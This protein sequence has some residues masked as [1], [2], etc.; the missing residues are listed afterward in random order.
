[1]VFLSATGDGVLTS[2]WPGDANPFGSSAWGVGGSATRP[3]QRQGS[4][5]GKP[6]VVTASSGNRTVPQSSRGLYPALDFTRQEA[7]PVKT[8]PEA[9]VTGFDPKLS[10]EVP[11][12]RGASHRTYDNPDGSRSTEFSVDPVHYRKPDGSWAPVGTK[13]TPA[14]GGGWRNTADAVNLRLAEW[15]DARD[16]ATIGLDAEHAISFGLNGATHT[17][18]RADGDTVTYPGALAETDLRLQAKA[19]SVKEILVLRSPKA[20]RSFV[21]PLHLSGLSASMAGGKVVLT[22]SSGKPRGVIPPGFMNDTGQRPATST[23]VRYELVKAGDAPALQVT[24]D[25]AWLDAPE[26]VYPVEVDPTVE[27]TIDRGL[28]DTSMVVQGS[29]TVPGSATLPAGMSGGVPTASY[30]KFNGLADTLRGQA[31]FGASLSLYNQGA[32]S[33]T[34]RPIGVYPV[35]EP[36][37]PDGRYSYPGPAVGNALASA[38]FAH[39]STPDA[40]GASCPATW[41]N[42]GLLTAGAAL[43]RQWVTD[44]AKNN[45]LSLRASDTDPT[46]WKSFG[47]TTSNVQPVLWVTHSDYDAQYDID[48]AV[49]NP[50]VLETKPGTLKVSVTNTGPATWDPSSVNLTYQVDGSPYRVVAASLAGSVPTNA[51]VQLDA[52]IEALPPGSHR[53]TFTMMHTTGQTGSPFARSLSVT[54]MVPDGSQVIRD[55]YPPNGYQAPTLTPQLSTVSNGTAAPGATRT[56]RFEICDTNAAKAPVNC[57]SH[58]APSRTLQIPANRLRWNRTYQ[59]RAFVSVNGQEGAPSPYSALLTFVPQPKVAALLSSAQAGIA[60]NAFD[61]QSGNYTTRATDAVVANAGPAL[62]VLRTYNSLD[63]RRD[64]M[65]GEGWSNR[66]DMRLTSDPDSS[67]NVVVTYVNG[68]QFRFGYNPQD[69]TYSPPPGRTE[70]LIPNGDGWNLLD[71][72]GTVY[73]FSASGRLI[74]ITDPSGRSVVLS[75]DATGTMLTK[76]QVVTADFGGVGRA[77]SFT[78]AGGHVT[79]VTTDPVAAYGADP[80]TAS[81]LIWRYTY[82]RDKLV[83]VCP[84][85]VT[86]APCTRYTYAAGSHYRSVVMDAGPASYWRLGEASGEPTAQSENITNLGVD[87]GA[88][89]NVALGAPGSLPGTSNT[90]ATFNGT[91]SWVQLRDNAAR[92]AS[93]STV[94]LWFN[95]TANGSGGPLLGYQD[96]KLDAGPTSGAPILYL[97]ADKRLVGQFGGIA[98]SNPIT[99]TSPVSVGWNHVVLSSTGAGQTLY[100]NGVKV[101][102][103]ND[104]TVDGTSYVNQIGAAYASAPGSWPG[105]GT[106]PSRFFAGAI[107]EVAVYHYALDQTTV[108]D[109]YRAGVTV[110]N[111]LTT[112]TTPGG[113]VAAQVTYNVGLDRVDTYTDSHGGTWRVSEPTVFGGGTDLRRTVEVSDP[114]DRPYPFEYDALTGQLLRSATPLDGSPHTVPTESCAAPSPQDTSFCVVD[115]GDRDD[116]ITIPG[117]ALA[118]RSYSYDDRGFLNQFVDETNQTNKL[119]LDGRGN[120]TSNTTCRT[121]SEC[122]TTY[123]T[124]PAT[125]QDPYDPRNN[126]PTAKRDARSSG[127]GDNTYLTSYNY[128]DKGRVQTKTVAGAGTTTYTYT[129]KGDLGIPGPSGKLLPA[130]LVSSV[131]DGRG[132]TTF[133]N[134]YSTGDT[135]SVSSPS[136]SRVQ[137]DYDGVG[138][139][140]RE[141]SYSDTFPGGVATVFGYDGE[142]RQVTVTSPVTV[143]QVDGT[144]HQLRITNSYD[145]DGNPTGAETKDLL[146]GDPA[147]DT[148]VSYDEHGNPWNVVDAEDNETTFEFDRF[149]NKTSE[150]DGNGRHFDYS[151]NARNQVTEKRLRKGSG[152][153]ATADADVVLDSY[154]YDQE[155]VLVSHTDA[156]G[157]TTRYTHYNDGLLFQKILQNFHGPD[158]TVRDFVL[159]ENTYDGVGNR[160]RQ[161][162]ADR[163]RTTDNTYDSASR[164]A[165]TVDDPGGLKRKTAY[166]YDPN[167]NVTGV[168][169]SGLDLQPSGA[170]VTRVTRMTYDDGGNLVRQE[171]TGDGDTRVTTHTYDQRGLLTGTTDPRGNA[172]GDPAA[173]TTTYQNDE[174]GRQ[175]RTTKPSVTAETFGRTPTTTRPTITVGYNAFGEAVANRDESGNVRSASYDRLG[176]LVA[177]RAPAYTS[178]GANSP[179]VPTTRVTYD[180]VGNL[181]QTVDPLNHV[182]N[183]TYDALDRVITADG[184]GATDAERALYSYTYALSGEILSQTDPVG[185][186]TTV[187]YD[188][189]DRVITKTDVE[190]NAGNSNFT[191]TFQYDPAGNLTRTTTPGGVVTTTSYSNADEPLM[192]ASA[193]TASTFRYDFLGR[194]V[195]ERLGPQ[196]QKPDSVYRTATAT[197]DQSGQVT[198]QTDY[199]TDGTTPLR[200]RTS[201]YDKAGNRVRATDAYKH[202]V[203]F[204]YDAANRL[205]TQQ[206]K[207][208][209]PDEGNPNDPGPLNW[210]EISFGYDAAGNRTRATDGRGNA[211]FTTFNAL[212]LPESVIE[213]ATRAH[214]DLA[215]RAW[216]TSYDARGA[217]VRLTAP[218][219]VVRTRTYDAGGRMVAEDG[220]GGDSSKTPEAHR[221]LTYDTAGQLVGVNTPSGDNKFTYND[222]GDLVVAAGP[223]GTASFRYN[224]DDQ[225][226]DRVD[227]SGSASF[228]YMEGRLS[229]ATH[230]GTG[231]IQRFGYNGTGNLETI[232]YGQGRV[233]TFRYDVLGR[234]TSDTLGNPRGGRGISTTY[235]YDLNDR[236]TTRIAAGT[237]QPGTSTYTHDQIGRLTSWVDELGNNT[238]YTWDNAG[239]RLQAGRKLAVFD[240]RNRLL[241]DG[242]YIYEY[243]SRGTLS[244]RSSSGKVDEYL[245][246]AF[247]RMVG[248]GVAT[249]TYDGLDRAASHSGQAFTYAGLSDDP[250]A[251]GTEKYSRMPDGELLGVTRDDDKRPWLAVTDQHGDVVTGFDAGASALRFTNSTGYDPF[252]EVL[253]R[254]GA[255]SRVGFQGDWTD[256][257]TELVNMGA[258]W[259]NPGAGAFASRD[260]IDDLETGGPSVRANRYTYGGADPIDAVDPDGH[261]WFSRA[262][263]TVKGAA[264]TVADTAKSAEHKVADAASTAAIWVAD[265]QADIAGIA[266]NILVNVGCD[267]VVGESVVGVV[268]CAA[269]AGVAGSLTH[270]LIEGG[271]TP[272]EM[273]RNA[274]VEGAINGASAGVLDGM[275]SLVS[276]AIRKAAGGAAT[277]GETAVRDVAEAAARDAEAGAAKAGADSA[278]E[279]AA[280]DS[281]AG[282]AESEAAD[283]ADVADAAEPE[284]CN[285][286]APDTP[287]LMADGS[288]KQ[289]SRIQPG[290][291]VMA[292]D[293]TTGRTAGREVTDTIVGQ[294]DKNL[295]RITVDTDGA[296]GEATGTVVAT[297]AHPFWVQERNAWVDATDLRPGELLR[298]SAG[299]YVQITAVQRWTERGQRVHNLT[300]DEI[301]T[302]YVVTGGTPVLVHN[303]KCPQGKIAK[304][305]AK[306]KRAKAYENARKFDIDDPA[307]T[308]A[309]RDGIQKRWKELKSSWSKVAKGVKGKASEFAKGLKAKLYAKLKELYNGNLVCENPE[310]QRILRPPTQSKKGTLTDILEARGDHRFP[311]AKGGKG[312]EGNFQILCVICNAIKSKKFPWKPTVPHAKGA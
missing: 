152:A 178:V 229:T 227:A 181:V 294:G 302:Y 174:L 65:F 220:T 29:G 211:T 191:T 160:T 162:T 17:A 275:G 242:D 23:G 3:E 135:A 258:R 146:T 40:T 18:G 10:R 196:D 285:S 168:T 32:D 25:S 138:R 36:W 12:A 306:A 55:L 100:L 70:S 295:V 52:V 136:G 2:L 234:L 155:G 190:R 140:V 244:S 133:Y 186:V 39:R 57:T 126:R 28:A 84:P 237:T 167:G 206:E 43:V 270:D 177:E 118:I 54:L 261:S 59:W 56:Y 49:P 230:T 225:I 30:L 131:T 80:A 112:M 154:A 217:A 180:R 114:A 255:T 51:K 248:A 150:R 301:H 46:A 106:A 33:C 235:T 31:I 171:V 125:I 27:S 298:T 35:T 38:T 72:S 247:D 192:T 7:Q 224:A 207:V 305:K 159:E 238:A 134:Y 226:L 42:M 78:W 241:T 102:Q 236:I 214:P 111:A 107:D 287:V 213:P 172:G 170:P 19:G 297:D 259:A 124:Y 200:T 254:R 203:T 139:K 210:I 143:D 151:Y 21:F 176:Q 116:P 202:P 60:G 199:D 198:T 216:T 292:T 14:D 129:S 281:A 212:N 145:A 34:P 274:L 66:Y 22:D 219:G 252:G 232:D 105:W 90:A 183:F 304:A 5:A 165:S 188:D 209:G 69:Q 256:P 264:N 47:G 300:V 103:A 222:R 44:P 182:S 311:H 243:T 79:T 289:I 257:A 109:H 279:S 195:S 307:L 309:Q 267:A 101:G 8:L 68:Q 91:S 141:T 164:V 96:K 263:N 61:P 158:G 228:T 208:S 187:T 99:T 271:H 120:V 92:A 26:R 89:H 245:F 53:L 81:P 246:D 115:H 24:L 283:A 83:Q 67:G 104:R 262:W 82:E 63:P 218:G 194:R 88:Y 296:A 4:A 123:W 50:P 204:T 175:V 130:G 197:Y 193:G 58:S 253:Y 110:S 251:D 280:A 240:E 201:T 144:R 273:L 119:T 166:T 73:Q 11:E 149:G 215:D 169:R 185:A 9:P 20:P 71:G 86:V 137:Y 276:S 286:F 249:Y 268:G 94:E 93:E 6:H 15:A 37:T 75:Y 161:V 265:H 173:Y 290:E 250:I 45:G 288:Q 233:R 239:N 269:L 221:T 303:V 231:T 85:G 266:V 308:D 310:C 163:T 64:S 312:V 277:A 41:E 128:D 97:T 156:M 148:D 147:R 157:R 108:R 76:V 87:T 293:P 121:I 74:R 48:N 113:R 278:A 77:L 132:E 189:L 127:P 179:I 16:V 1:M 282:G 122:H 142:S 117:D 284:E 95:A 299:T 223:S 153:P 260:S 291:Q 184:P 205:V 62:S 13:L 98:S 272:N